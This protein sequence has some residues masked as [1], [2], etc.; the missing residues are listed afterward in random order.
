MKKLI[1]MLLLLMLPMVA[2]ATK[3]GVLDQ[4]VWCGHG[5]LKKCE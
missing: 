3:V 2:N 4:P 5:E 1:M